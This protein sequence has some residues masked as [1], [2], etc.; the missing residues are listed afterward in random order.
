MGK[1][2]RSRVK[3]CKTKLLVRGNIETESQFSPEKGG[4]GK[5]GPF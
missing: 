3:T 2:R 5:K 4:F 1:E